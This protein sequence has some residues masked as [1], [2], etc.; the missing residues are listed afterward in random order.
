ML[1]FTPGP[2]EVHPR[3]LQAMARPLQN[4]DLDP[5]FFTF[6]DELCEKVKRILRTR[7]D[8]ILHCGEAIIGLEAAVASLVAPGEKVL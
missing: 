7:S 3:V 6:Y 1:M 8:V 5:D 2:T 4:P